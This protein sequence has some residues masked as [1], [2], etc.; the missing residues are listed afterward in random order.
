MGIFASAYN[1][2]CGKD[3]TSESPTN[4]THL[5][6]IDKRTNSSKQRSKN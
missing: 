6:T 3:E 2:K 1:Y 5:I 4:E